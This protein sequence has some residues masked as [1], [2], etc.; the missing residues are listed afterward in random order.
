MDHSSIQVNSLRSWRKIAVLPLGL[1][2]RLW[3]RSLRL[4]LPWDT[5]RPLEKDSRG[6]LVL[7]WHNRLLPALAT[8]PR[9]DRQGKN[10][11]ALISASRDGAWLTAFAHSLGL[12][13]IRGSSS[14][15]GAN[16]MREILRALREGQDVGITVDGPR[17]PAYEAKPGIGLLAKLSGAPIIYVVPEIGRGWRAK[18]WDRFCVPAPLTSLNVR[19]EVQ[20]DAAE[21]WADLPHEACAAEIGKRLRALTAGNDPEMGV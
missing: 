15:R 12:R 8:Y 3:Q 16:A 13:V 7:T 4:N 11:H 19:I 18:S 20:Q 6:F 21:R 14:R 2:M 17:G 1:T 5:I 10:L 9:V